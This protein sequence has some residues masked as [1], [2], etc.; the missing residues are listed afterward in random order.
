MS[1]DAYK[2]TYNIVIFFFY[3]RKGQKNIRYQKRS[4]RNH[5]MVHSQEDLL[6][7][8]HQ[9]KVAEVQRIDGGQLGP[10]LR[11][12]QVHVVQILLIIGLL[13]SIILCFWQSQV[14]LTL[15]FSCR[16]LQDEPHICS[17]VTFFWVLQV[18]STVDITKKP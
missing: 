5:F 12:R 7:I 9:R 10:Y 2:T 1:L 6:Q 3:Y 17:L 8:H 14:E 16:L 13:P 18:F 4:K 11:T 15:C